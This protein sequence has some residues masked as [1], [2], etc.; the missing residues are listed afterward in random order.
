MCDI[1]SL[2]MMGIDFC[3]FSVA[4]KGDRDPCPIHFF[5]F[6]VV[7]PFYCM[8]PP[9]LRKRLWKTWK[10]CKLE[11]IDIINSNACVCNCNN[12]NGQYSTY[13]LDTYHSTL[14]SDEYLEEKP[15]TYLSFH[16]FQKSTRKF[17]WLHCFYGDS[18][19]FIKSLWWFLCFW[20]H[21]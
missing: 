2:G 1:P 9:L 5:G 18:I 16:H 10:I 21:A 8:A 6:W 15:I 3:E 11:I 12:N 14:V 19:D 7:C 13:L 20:R 4:V 17:L